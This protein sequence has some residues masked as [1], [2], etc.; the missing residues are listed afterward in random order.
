M[1]PYNAE[2]VIVDYWGD[3]NVK[4]LA[5]LITDVIIKCP[6]VEMSFAAKVMPMT[7]SDE[8]VNDYRGKVSST[9]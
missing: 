9:M 5:T 4:A 6:E 8:E 3:G 1:K 7:A 2:K